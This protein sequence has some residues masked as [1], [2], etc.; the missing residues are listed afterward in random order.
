[1]T[2]RRATAFF[3]YA[4]TARDRRGQLDSACV[5]SLARSPPCPGNPPPFVLLFGH[6]AA[7]L[8]NHA[9]ISDSFLLNQFDRR[10][11]FASPLSVYLLFH[12]VGRIIVPESF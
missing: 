11:F 3:L 8:P 5:I 4:C 7:R 1:M 10:F 9:I 12:S 6:L 2:E